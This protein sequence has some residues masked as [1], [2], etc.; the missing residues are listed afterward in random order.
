MA[1]Q[2][3]RGTNAER[4]AITPL[5]G[6]L[7]YVTDTKQLYVGDGTTLGGTTT[8]Q[9]TIDS[10]LADSTP[11]LGGSLDLNGND[12][13]GTGNINITGT[14][15]ATGNI[16]LGDGAGGDQIS[17][18]GVINGDLVP[19]QDGQHDL[20]SASAFWKEAWIEQLTVDSQITAERVN[21]DIIADDSTV[22]FNSTTGLIAAA[23]VSGTL[24]NDV[25]GNITGDVVG[26]TTGY[27]TGDVK[28]SVFADDSSIMVDSVGNSL[29]ATNAT[30]TGSTNV[31]ALQTNS[32]TDQSTNGILEIDMTNTGGNS[33]PRIELKSDGASGTGMW[34]MTEDT[35]RTLA[36]TDNIGRILFRAVDAAGTHTPAVAIA[37][38]DELI[39]AVGSKNTAETFHMA[40]AT[41]NY[42][43]G[44]EPSADAKVNVGGAMLL[45][46]MDTTTRD[47]L[48]AANGMIIYNTT[49]NKFQGYE[50]GSWANLI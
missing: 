36:G 15:T 49:D 16:N 45:G 33:Q 40:T 23:Q 44:I 48:T 14:I 25:I 26:N 38:K 34:I 27:H 30:I 21:A 19:D 7:I 5:E 50:N 4:L 41:G 39:I 32:I 12:I 3:R 9:N 22:V 11:Q 46:N 35:G 31:V 2:V 47:G 17:V 43:L 42:G 18:G 6:E 20:G 10:L 8:I 1:L 29:F 37:R 24:S 28:G 13:T